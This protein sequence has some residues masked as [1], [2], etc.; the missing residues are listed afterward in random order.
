MRELGAEAPRLHAGLADAL[1]VAKIDLV[2][3]VGP[4]M[5]HLRDALP[6]TMRGGHAER[7]DD[8]TEPVAD[9]VGGGDVVMVKGSL[10]TRMAP[11]VAALAARDAGGR[12]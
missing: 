10:G 3:T 1:T 11:I 8:L 2:F 5:A 7:S 12:N 6:E 4:N 9:A